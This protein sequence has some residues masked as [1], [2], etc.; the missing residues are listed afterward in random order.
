LNSCL[1]VR[2]TRPFLQKSPGTSPGLNRKSE[3]LQSLLPTW[4][5][6]LAYAGSDCSQERPFSCGGQRA[7]VRSVHAF[8]ANPRPVAAQFVSRRAKSSRRILDTFG[9][10]PAWVEIVRELKWERFHGN[11]SAVLA[12]NVHGSGD[13]EKP[14]SVLPECFLDF[15]A[16]DDR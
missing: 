11:Q 4:T 8:E 10:A 14:E 9:R 1:F 13:R 2:Q 16:M 5:A 6:C 3:R 7:V 12:E 15:N